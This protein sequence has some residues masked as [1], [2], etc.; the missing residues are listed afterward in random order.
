MESIALVEASIQDYVETTATSNLKSLDKKINELNKENQN[1]K[2]DLEVR[3]KTINEHKLQ[4][5]S[6]SDRV[7][8]LDQ[9]CLLFEKTIKDLESSNLA[10]KDQSKQPNSSRKKSDEQ[11]TQINYKERCEIIAKDNK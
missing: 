7:D 1:L 2:T 10:Q 11:K 6:L 5:R 4:I 9:H 8:Y 3:D